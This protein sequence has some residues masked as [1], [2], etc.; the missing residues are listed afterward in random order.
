MDAALPKSHE[1]KKITSHANA[2]LFRLGTPLFPGEDEQDQIACIMEVVGLP[3][4]SVMRR[5]R[6]PHHFFTES[7]EPRYLAEKF[8][9]PESRVGNRNSPYHLENYYDLAM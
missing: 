8:E 4:P 3:P 7:G 5:L 6:R 2:L 9:K 1:K